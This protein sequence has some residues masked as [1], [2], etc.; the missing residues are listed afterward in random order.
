MESWW[1]KNFSLTQFNFLLY[2]QSSA[3]FFS[4]FTGA[5]GSV[6][7]KMGKLLTDVGHD[8]RD[9]VDCA[10]DA[11]EEVIYD[12]DQIPKYYD[13]CKETS[14]EANSAVPVNNA[15]QSISI[16]IKPLVPT[17]PTEVTSKSV[18][19]VVNDR[20][21]IEKQ[22]AN[23]E[24]V[25]HD[26]YY[27]VDKLS[28]HLD[29]KFDGLS[30]DVDEKLRVI[31]EEK[32]NLQKT[33]LEIKVLHLE[34]EMEIEK[35]KEEVHKIYE[36]ILKSMKSSDLKNEMT[37][38]MKDMEKKSSKVILEEI[39]K[40]KEK[41]LAQ[42]KDSIAD[43][44]IQGTTEIYTPRTFKELTAKM[45]KESTANDAS[46]ETT[47]ISINPIAL[48]TRIPLNATE[49]TTKSS[50]TQASI[51]ITKIPTTHTSTQPTDTK[52]MTPRLTITAKP[53]TR[54][55]FAG[56]VSSVSTEIL[57]STLPSVTQSS[58]AL[59]TDAA[60]NATTVSATFTESAVR[61]KTVVITTTQKPI[62]HSTTV[63]PSSTNKLVTI[64]HL[65]TR[66]SISSTSTF[67][68][69]T[70]TKHVTQT[71]T[72][73]I[74]PV[75]KEIITTKKFNRPST[76]RKFAIKSPNRKK[77]AKNRKRK[78][79]QRRHFKPKRKVT[80]PTPRPEPLDDLNEF[81]PKDPLSAVADALKIF[82]TNM[83]TKSVLDNFLKHLDKVP[84]SKVF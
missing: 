14:T 30:K 15:Q 28:L 18:S 60:K 70:S 37:D 43:I 36:E 46:R 24:A 1:F 73:T 40:W 39:E 13:K 81:A 6:K 44:K 57:N 50:V 63:I 79:K 11:V 65:S 69:S 34:E 8:L 83:K 76:T 27:H 66:P 48:D 41:G 4:D 42:L 84:V 59:S 3:S 9:T 62:S 17:S 31:D 45:F 5:L 7:S 35:T 20:K 80:K 26:E 68:T 33:L 38:A 72:S 12:K 71:S 56:I 58:L 75:I 53:V 55:T 67:A 16:Y 82:G 64:A 61:S 23:V 47:T 19:A 25:V 52:P 2:F 21:D 51:S 78:N 54:T 49:I 32:A 10:V 77:Q 29:T 22:L 74:K